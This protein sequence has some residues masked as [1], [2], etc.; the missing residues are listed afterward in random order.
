MKHDK[1]LI[2]R[3]DDKT[4]D[5]LADVQKTMG[6]HSRSEAL[7]RSIYIIKDLLSALKNGERLILISKD[8]IQRELVSEK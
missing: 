3:V 6:L 8:G 7:R 1:I 4:I 2:A 5:R